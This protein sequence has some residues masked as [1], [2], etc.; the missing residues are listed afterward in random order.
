MSQANRAASPD[1]APMLGPNASLIGERDARSR[2]ATP[3]LLI[4]IET[5]DANLAKM[6]A[7]CDRAGVALRPHAKAH[8]CPEIARRQLAAGATGICVATPGEA[9][10]FAEA[11]IDDILLTSTFATDSA[12]RRVVAVMAQTRL[13]CVVD[14]PS[15]VATLGALATR[16][17]IEAEVLIDVDLFRHRAGVASPRDAAELARVIEATEGV[18]L[19]GIQGY[20]G[21][22]SHC[23]EVGERRR[24]AEQARA[25]LS[26]MRDAIEDASGRKADWITGG[27]TGALLQEMEGVYT[28][29]QCGSYALM[30]TEYAAVDPD[31]SGQP[32]FPPSLFLAAAVTS[33]NHPGLATT[34]GGEKRLASKYGV[35]PRVMR[36]AP[37]GTEYRA[38]SDEH[39][40][41]LLPEGE[42]VEL[43][44]LVEVEVPHCDP[45]VNLFD[46]IHVVRGET[47][48]AIWPI[49]ARGC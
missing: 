7:L 15:I 23:R 40:Q 49:E 4:D 48:E 39:G 38:T 37:P 44:A 3:A 34:D 28:E 6:Q 20:A 17:G 36:G 41:L 9:E 35:P 19:A 32:L 12:C 21:H 16:A 1:A 43:G 14:H 25:M 26:G 2:L 45:T 27:S 31:G 5:L 29:F 18:R 47:L 42:W 11:G 24:G 13:V 8:K 22:L 33:A 46:H 30:D 10:C